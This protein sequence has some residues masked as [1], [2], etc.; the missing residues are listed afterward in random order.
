MLNV[1]YVKLLEQSGIFRYITPDNYEKAADELEI[2][3]MKYVNNQVIFRQ[4]DKASQL[5]LVVSGEV[6]A[7]KIHG[8]GS[9]NMVHSYLFSNMFAHEGA[10]SNSRVYPMDYIS[11][12][13]SQIAFIDIKKLYSSSF[14][15]ELLQGIVGYMADESIRRMYRIEIMSKKKLRDRILTYLRIKESEIGTSAFTLDISREQLAYEL[16]VN[17]S[18]LSNELGKMQR[19]GLIS[20]DKRKIT[21]SK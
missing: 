14:A 16:C 1:N 15:K 13:D 7:E 11:D 9:D 18:A 5:A 12:G 19:E 20:I 10:I 17:R 21:L 2:T 8:S 6:K 4:N 3:S